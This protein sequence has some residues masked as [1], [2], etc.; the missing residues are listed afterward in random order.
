MPYTPPRNSTVFSLYMDGVQI[1]YCTDQSIQSSKDLPEYTNKN[2]NGF[3][4]SMSGTFSASGS[5]SL[6]YI[7]N[8]TALWAAHTG[9]SPIE[10]ALTDEVTGNDYFTGDAHINEVSIN[11]SGQNQPVTAS[12]SFE[13]TGQYQMLTNP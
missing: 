1:G 13:Y 2:S 5:T 7:E 4:E 6:F 3:K 8:L 11:S 9:T 10:M 12:I